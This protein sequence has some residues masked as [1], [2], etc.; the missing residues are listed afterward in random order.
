MLDWQ[1]ENLVSNDS[2][3]NGMSVLGPGKAT[4]GQRAMKL[5]LDGEACTYYSNIPIEYLVDVDT[6]TYWCHRVGL[7]K[8][9][10]DNNIGSGWA[11]VAKGTRSLTQF[12]NVSTFTHTMRTQ[13]IHLH[14]HKALLAEPYQPTLLVALAS[15]S[16]G[17]HSSLTGVSYNRR[18][19]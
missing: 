15:Q 19:G 6:D 4:V 17:S 9:Y 14:S 1:I 3:G 13:S 8:L 12:C 5:A 2:N 16:G 7:V 18:G 10:D 11:S